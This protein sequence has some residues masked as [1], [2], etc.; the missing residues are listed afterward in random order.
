MKFNKNKFHILSLRS[1]PGYTYGLGNEIQE[2]SPAERVMGVLIDNKLNMNEQH[3]Q[4]ARK[5]N[6]ILRCIKHTIAGWS[7]EMIVLL[8]TGAASPCVMCAV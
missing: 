5:A 3:V 4:A 2:S 8:Y 1:N 7:R 6:R